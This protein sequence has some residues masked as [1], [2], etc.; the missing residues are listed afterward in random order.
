[1]VIKNKLKKNRTIVFAYNIL[2]S[3]FGLSREKR[4]RYGPWLYIYSL[5]NRDRYKPLKKYKNLHKGERC[6]IVGTGPSLDIEDV[7]RLKGE[8]SI[9][10]NTL[11]KLYDKTDWRADYYCIIDPNTYDNLKNDLLLNNV[12]DIFYPDNRFVSDVLSGPR[13]IL[14]HSDMYKMCF[15][16]IFK[17][18]K[19]SSDISKVVYDGASVIYAS[20]QIAVYMGFKEIYLL[21]VDCNFTTGNTRHGAGLS[22]D[23][24]KYN[25]TENTG[26][27]MIEGFKVAKE[28]ADKHNIKIYNATRGGKL[29]IFERVDFDMIIKK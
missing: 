29:E 5:K 20:L 3:I 28:Y 8:I 12:T 26:Y 22:Y 2:S 4:L 18:T 11:F 16:E 19:F 1:M 15:P 9:G 13:F 27:T 14:N 17:F 23:N 24:Y 10:V 21:G 6:F 25:W 7:N